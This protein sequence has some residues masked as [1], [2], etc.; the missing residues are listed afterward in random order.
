[1]R[2]MEDDVF[3]LSLVLFL[4]VFFAPAI[5]FYTIES[6]RDYFKEKSIGFFLKYT[7]IALVAYLFGILLF[8]LL[9]NYSLFNFGSTHL[10]L[11]HIARFLA[12]NFLGAILLYLFTPIWIRFLPSKNTRKPFFY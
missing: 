4:L 11:D 9:P 7:F 6:R 10:S 5:L 8:F 1:M 3:R 12:M 2:K